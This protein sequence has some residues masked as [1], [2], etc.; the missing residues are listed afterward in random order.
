MFVLGRG[1]V[2]DNRIFFFFKSFFNQI[3][4][5]HLIMALFAYVPF[6]HP[7]PLFESFLRVVDADEERRVTFCLPSTGS[8]PGSNH[9]GH[10]STVII[11]LLLHTIY[12]PQPLFQLVLRALQN[13]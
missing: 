2:L 4:F 12:F 5:L 9:D 13:I 7:L 8:N 3:Y 10:L 11:L 1:V 6:F